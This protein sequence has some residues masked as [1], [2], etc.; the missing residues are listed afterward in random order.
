MIAN[1]YNN[2]ITIEQVNKYI[3]LRQQFEFNRIFD[4]KQIF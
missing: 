4:N 1:K 3:G 2:E